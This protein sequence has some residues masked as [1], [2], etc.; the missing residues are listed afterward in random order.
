MSLYMATPKQNISSGIRIFFFK[1]FKFFMVSFI[2]LR[3]Y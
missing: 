1:V 2:I 3:Y